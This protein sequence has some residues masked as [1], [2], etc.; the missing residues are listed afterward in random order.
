MFTNFWS[1]PRITID[2]TAR[3]TPQNYKKHKSAKRINLT[4]T[5]AAE[6]GDNVG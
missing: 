4:V 5:K 3:E 6:V 1:E 2:A